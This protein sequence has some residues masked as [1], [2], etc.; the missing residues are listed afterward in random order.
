M[1][2]KTLL[3]IALIVAFLGLIVLFLLPPLPSTQEIVRVQWAESGRA[4]VLLSEY[5][6][7]EYTGY[8]PHK[9]ECVEMKGIKKEGSVLN[10]HFAPV[11][12]E[13]RHHCP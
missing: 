1:N 12:Q 4:R 5:A 6:W 10:A 11:A 3:S 8:A 7:V 2:E 13:D 9:N